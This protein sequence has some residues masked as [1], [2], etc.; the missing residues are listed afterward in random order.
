MYSFFSFGQT[1]IFL[2]GGITKAT[3]PVAV[4]LRS[5]DITVLSGN[6]R[7][8]Y[9]AVPRILPQQ[10]NAV[11]ADCFGPPDLVDFSEPTCKLTPGSVAKDITQA[12]DFAEVCE[13]SDNAEQE[14]EDISRCYPVICSSSLKDGTVVRDVQGSCD[15]RGDA[16]SCV[17]NPKCHATCDHAIA[18]RTNDDTVRTLQ[19]LAW[20]PLAEYI[21]VNRINM[22]VRQ[23]FR[24]GQTFPSAETDGPV[25]CSSTTS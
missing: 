12:S 9:H 19:V 8:A 6:C 10:E 4:Y 18:N 3:V 5:G 14:Q 7:V 15:D 20:E 13:D 16:Q 11:F 25:D 22:N 17:G 24:R 21:A 23:V 1:A 2:L